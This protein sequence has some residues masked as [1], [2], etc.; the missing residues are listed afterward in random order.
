MASPLLVGYVLATLFTGDLGAVALALAGR[1]TV[2]TPTIADFQLTF[3]L[4]V[5]MLAVLVLAVGSAITGSFLAVRARDSFRSPD[6]DLTELVRTYGLG[7]GRPVA[8]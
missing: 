5:I 3:E 6:M 8:S 1:F 2:L 7:G 4:V